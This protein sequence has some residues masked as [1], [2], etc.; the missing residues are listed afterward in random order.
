LARFESNRYFGIGVFYSVPCKDRAT[1]DAA[2]S[3]Q[4]RLLDLCVRHAGRP[5][6]CG[7]HD[8]SDS[9]MESIF[10]DEYRQLREVCRQLDPDGLFNRRL[11]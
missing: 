8:I 9:D 11:L 7:A 2:R 10:G 1:L 6:L 3:A 5:Y 4:R